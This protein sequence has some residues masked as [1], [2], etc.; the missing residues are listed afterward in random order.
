MLYKKVHRQHIRQFWK[1]RKFRYNGGNMVGEVIGKP[2]IESFG[3]I[4]VDVWCLIPIEGPYK[5]RMWRKDSI[6][7]LD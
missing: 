4:Y 5:G 2:Y 3:A 1:G 7:W 6:E